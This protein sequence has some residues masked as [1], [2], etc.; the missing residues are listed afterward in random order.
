MKK[1]REEKLKLFEKFEI[2]LQL[3]KATNQSVNNFV[4][5]RDL[6]SI[7]PFDPKKISL[8]AIFT[9]PSGKRIKRYGFYF[10]ATFG[11][12]Q[13]FTNVDFG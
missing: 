13:V 4:F 10:H 1:L 8:E 7:N 9:A 12:G 6:Q 2:K 5:R 3:D 11:V